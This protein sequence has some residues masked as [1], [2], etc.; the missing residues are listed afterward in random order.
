MI[1]QST[2]INLM[3]DFIVYNLNF[4]NS[5]F[6]GLSLTCLLEYLLPRKLP[7]HTSYD[8]SAN[9][10]AIYKNQYRYTNLNVLFL[11]IISLNYEGNDWKDWRPKCRK[12][13][14]LR[15]GGKRLSWDRWMFER[16]CDEFLKCIHRPFRR[17]GSQLDSH[18]SWWLEATKT[19]IKT[20]NNCRG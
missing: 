8:L 9:N 2:P 17:D 13:Q 16:E 10:I 7:N 11:R 14:E 20:R 6:W 15:A 18:D 19:E 5:V 12:I 3:Y 1:F 4:Q